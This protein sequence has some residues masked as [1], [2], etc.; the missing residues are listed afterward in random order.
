MWGF[1]KYDHVI[2]KKWFGRWKM[3][4]MEEIKRLRLALLVHSILYYKFDYNIISDFEYDCMAKKLLKLQTEN[5]DASLAVVD[6]LYAFKD[7]NGSSGFKLPLED[8]WANYKA[9]QLMM[10]H[11]EGKLI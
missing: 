6:Y 7:W 2:W 3:K 5:A 8:S 9:T 4:I 10:W 11:K 1:L